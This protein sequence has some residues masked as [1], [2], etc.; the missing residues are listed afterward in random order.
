LDTTS[1]FNTYTLDITSGLGT[2]FVNNVAVSSLGIGPTD[3]VGGTNS[4]VTF[5]DIT[6]F[7]NSQTQLSSLSFGTV[8]EPASLAALGVFGLALRP[9]ALRRRSER[10]LQ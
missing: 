7:D 3:Y 5:G 9:R 4:V 10:G 1:A 8:P 6:R 2:L